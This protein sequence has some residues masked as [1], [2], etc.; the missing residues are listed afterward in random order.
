M[1][2]TSPSLWQLQ[3]SVELEGRAAATV[4]AYCA[5]SGLN[6][7]LKNVQKSAQCH[8]PED[9]IVYLN[10]NVNADAYYLRNKLFQMTQP[11]GCLECRRLCTFLL[12]KLNPSFLVHFVTFMCPVS[13]LYH[14]SRSIRPTLNRLFMPIVG[15]FRLSCLMI[16]SVLRGAEQQ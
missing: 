13:H 1:E 10:E 3:I 9:R 14:S 15:L 11:V 5:V 16:R 8:K 6:W 12:Y 2:S 7:I 4:T